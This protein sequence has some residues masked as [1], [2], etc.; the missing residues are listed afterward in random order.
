MVRYK[1]NDGGRA[2]AGFKGHTG[3]CVTR[4]ICIATGSSYRETYT[5]L[6]I[7]HR[8]FL[9]TLTPAR[10]RSH[11]K[12]ISN[13]EM[14]QGKSRG[15]NMTVYEPVLRKLN[16]ACKYVG[17]ITPTQAVK[18]FGENLILKTPHHLVA[19]LDGVLL[20]TWNS[21]HSRSVE[22]V[23]VQRGPLPQITAPTVTVPVPTTFGPA[24][25]EI[26]PKVFTDAIR[27]RIAAEYLAGTTIPKLAQAW[28]RSASSIKA[29]IAKFPNG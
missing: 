4:A 2:A 21:S 14:D 1:Y 10:R 8:Q 16:W 17:R 9:H 29:I 3:D 27:R 15:I 25:G 23:W 19:I 7:A 24:A 18:Q 28:G 5:D 20:D 26:L 12:T 6:Q 13:A 11:G 22:R